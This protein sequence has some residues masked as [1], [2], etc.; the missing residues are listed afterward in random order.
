[1]RTCGQWIHW[2][3]GVSYNRLTWRCGPFGAT[4]TLVEL[5]STI[6]LKSNVNAYCKSVTA[7]DFRRISISPVLS[8]VFEHC[9]LERYGFFFTSSDNQ[10]GFKKKSSFYNLFLKIVKFDAFWVLVCGY[11]QLL[12][13]HANF[14]VTVCDVTPVTNY[15]LWLSRRGAHNF[16]KPIGFAIA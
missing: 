8:K 16:M 4:F 3:F 13:L 2:W 5:Y 1:M 11:I 10:F 9:I 12:V 7:D 14:S 15:A 6:I